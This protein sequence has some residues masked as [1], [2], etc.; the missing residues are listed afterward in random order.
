MDYLFPEIEQLT[1][2]TLVVI[3]NGFD[4][5]S[6]IES[7]Y[8]D[9]K[10]WLQNNSKHRL[11]GLMDTFFSNKRDVWGDIEKALGEYDE[12][13][14]LDYCKPDEEI[15]YDHAM[16]SMAAVEDA[17]D[18]IFKPVLDEFI[19]EFKNWVDSI[20]IANA[21]KIRD[22]PVECKYL[23]FNY[24]ET[25]E[26]VYAIPESN[27]LHIHGSRLSDKE[28]IIGHNNFRNPDD[29][30]NDES[31]MLYLQQTWSKIIEWMN[32]LIKDS[33]SIIRQKQNF[34]NSLSNIEQVVVYGHSFYEVD[35]P[36][37]EEIVKRIGI[38]KLWAISYYST[39]DLERIDSFVKKMGLKNVKTFNC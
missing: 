16:R 36:Y 13:S 34:F 4:L 10:Q 2:K 11:I 17:P 21:E 33:A 15:D 18:W 29:A 9:F 26:K 39:K 32:G 12:D 28:Y 19:E 3:G 35:W 23:T 38:D 31:Q 27:V 6:G 7:S 14:I 22:L 20:N 1:K 8:S 5:A 24:T 37:M 25:L 30:Y